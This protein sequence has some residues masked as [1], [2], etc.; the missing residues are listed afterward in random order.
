MHTKHH[1]P[2]CSAKKPLV[3]CLST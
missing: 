1:P 3:W 2:H